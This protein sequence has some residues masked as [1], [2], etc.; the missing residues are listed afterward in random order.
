MREITSVP[1]EYVVNVYTNS[2]KEGGEES[3]VPVVV[4]WFFETFLVFED[5]DSGGETHSES[6]CPFDEL[7]PFPFFYT[8]SF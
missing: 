7:I 6:Y 4:A 2:V 1:K 5:E 8:D 3:E